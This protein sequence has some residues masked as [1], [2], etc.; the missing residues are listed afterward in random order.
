MKLNSKSKK[1]DE[2]LKLAISCIKNKLSKTS[3]EFK[4]FKFQQN[5][6]IEFTK[7]DKDFKNKYFQ[8]QGLVQTKQ[9]LMI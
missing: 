1:Y 4:E 6:R 5:L 2:Q 7:N 9:N 8:T 3:K